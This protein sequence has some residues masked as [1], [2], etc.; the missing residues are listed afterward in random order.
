MT[1]PLA[2]AEAYCCGD[3]FCSLPMTAPELPNFFKIVAIS[4]ALATTSGHDG[5]RACQLRVKYEGG[6]AAAG[7]AQ[8]VG[9][10]VGAAGSACERWAPG[11]APIT[12]QQINAEIAAGGFSP[13][14]VAAMRAQAT[15]QAN[16]R[17]APMMHQMA[18]VDQGVDYFDR[19]V[20]RARFPCRSPTRHLLD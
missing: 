16:A 11:T 5:G 19:S 10:A 15:A 1:A 14:M 12:Q 20:L 9:T 13:Q 8:C 7:K 2:A 17:M 18:A 3:D 4:P 6:T